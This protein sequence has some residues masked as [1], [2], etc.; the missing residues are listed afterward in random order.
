MTP[1]LDG[2]CKHIETERVLNRPDTAWAFNRFFGLS[3]ALT[4]DELRDLLRQAGVGST[5]DIPLPV[6]LRGF[7]CSLNGASPIIIYRETDRIDVQKHTLLHETYEII[8]EMLGH[9]PRSIPPRTEPCAV[10]PTSLL[11]WCC[12]PCTC[13]TIWPSPVR[14]M[15]AC[16]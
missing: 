10:K 1:T 11:S 12:S 5:S 6:G 2:F 9:A 15:S 3:Y 8:Q 4:M 13:S 14:N 7:H 16:R